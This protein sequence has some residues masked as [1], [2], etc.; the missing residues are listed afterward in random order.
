MNLALHCPNVPPVTNP[1]YSG[2]LWEEN[3]LA[4]FSRPKMAIH[5]YYLLMIIPLSQSGLCSAP[6]LE[7]AK[8]ETQNKGGLTN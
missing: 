7:Y 4:P 5:A 2:P 3:I 6:T 8:E 1:K